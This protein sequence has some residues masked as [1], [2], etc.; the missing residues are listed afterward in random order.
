M[1]KRMARM[2]MNNAHGPGIGIGQ[3]GFGSES[4]NNLSVAVNNFRKG[5]VPGDS[6]EFS[7]SFRPGPFHGMEKPERRVDT[8]RIMP[9]FCTNGAPGERMLGISSYGKHTV[10]LYSHKETAGVG[11]I[12]R[13]NGAFE[14]NHGIY[15]QFLRGLFLLPG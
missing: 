12:V 11:A 1:K 2:K 8:L 4:G 3:D 9:H 10:I 6:L 15:L 5:L 7:L 14:L 13:T